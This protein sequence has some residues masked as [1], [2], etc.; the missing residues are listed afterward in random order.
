MAVKQSAQSSS[1]GAIPPGPILSASSTKKV[2]TAKRSARGGGGTIVPVYGER[3]PMTYHLFETEM[4][5]ISA[6]N[7]EALRYF[8]VGAFV[9]SCTL[10]IVIGDGF[11]T[12]PL[13]DFGKFMLHWGAPL[14]ALLAML[15]FG[16]GAYA[17][18]T[19]AALINQI[20]K[21]TVTKQ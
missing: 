13:T 12:D 6:L 3:R 18:S 20:K 2:A 14:S 9:L 16:L 5:S 8:S 15:C 11:A 17:V 1:G 10:T 21:E 19:K 4:Q 7:G